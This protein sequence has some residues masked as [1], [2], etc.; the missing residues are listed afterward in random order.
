M[1]GSWPILYSYPR[2]HLEKLWETENSV[3]MG[4]LRAKSR[5]INGFPSSAEVNNMWSDTSTSPRVSMAWCLIKHKGQLY[6]CRITGSHGGE[7]EDGCLLVKVYKRFR[8]SCYFHHQGATTQKTANF[9]FTYG[10]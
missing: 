7:Y 10:F 6:L 5:I 8:G 9:I 1:K 2:I 4:C 3:S